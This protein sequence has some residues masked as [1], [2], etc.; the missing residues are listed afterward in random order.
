MRE[1]GDQEGVIWA[2]INLGTT[3]RYRDDLTGATASAQP[4]PR[5]VRGTVVSRGDRLRR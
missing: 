3:A 2:L 5:P 1:L 4:V